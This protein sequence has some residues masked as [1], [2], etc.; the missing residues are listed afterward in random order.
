MSIPTQKTEYGYEITGPDN[1]GILVL[2]VGENYEGEDE[3]VFFSN[4]DLLLMLA[5]FAVG[6]EGGKR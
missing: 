1:N 3:Y 5:R 4:D 2:N 6:Y